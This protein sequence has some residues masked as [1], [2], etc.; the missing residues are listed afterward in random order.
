MMTLAFEL[1]LP[2]WL[3]GLLV[4]LFVIISFMLTLIILI[5]KPQG[6]GLSEAFGSGSGSGHTAFGA[7]T[8]DALTTATIGIFVVFILAAIF[9]NYAVRPP[10]AVLATDPAVTSTTPTTTPGA[11]PNTPASTVPVTPVTPGAP[12]SSM[13]N[14]IP[15]QTAPDGT[16]RLPPAPAPATAPAT[17]PAQPQTQPTTPPAGEQPA[18]PGSTPPSD[19]PQ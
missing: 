18:Q 11:A 9:L 13:E 6:G 15:L 3:I 12:G 7:K 14:A 16:L 19:K 5:Q 17:T 2:V 8:G 4:S 1:D 10:A